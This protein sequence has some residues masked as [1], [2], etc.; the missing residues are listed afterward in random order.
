VATT[1]TTAAGS[2]PGPK[3]AASFTAAAILIG[4]QARGA[5]LADKMQ[6]ANVEA[7]RPHTTA[8]SRP[9]EVFGANVRA[10]RRRED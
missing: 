5:R 8:K 10:L 7:Q 4:K 3:T 9:R 2:Y 1:A 6:Q